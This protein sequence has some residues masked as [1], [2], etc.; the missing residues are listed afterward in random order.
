FIVCRSAAATCSTSSRVQA[1][2]PKGL[3]KDP[4]ATQWEAKPLA[5]PAAQASPTSLKT[6]L[7]AVSSLAYSFLALAAFFTGLAGAVT[8]GAAVLSIAG[9]AVSSAKTGAANSNIVAAKAESF[10]IVFALLV[11][12]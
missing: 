12:S 6:F 1:A 4:S 10:F 7:M 11:N 9:A 8:A 3:I 5:S 2:W